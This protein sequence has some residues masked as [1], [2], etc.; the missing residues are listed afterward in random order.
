LKS[1]LGIS[2]CNIAQNAE[3]TNF[4]QFYFEKRLKINKKSAMFPG[5]L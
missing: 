5:V 3:K 4:A 1:L 2:A